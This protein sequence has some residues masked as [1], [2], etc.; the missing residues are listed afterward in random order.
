MD[1]LRIIIL[2][3]L[4]VGCSPFPVQYPCDTPKFTISDKSKDISYFDTSG[5][6]E[7]YCPAKV[8]ERF[9]LHLNENTK[10]TV[11]VRGEWI[12]LMPIKNGAQY[13]VTGKEIRDMEFEGYTQAI[14]V[15][16]LE[17]NTLTLSFTDS[18]SININVSLVKC[19]CVTYD[20]I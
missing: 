19:T 10:V 13:K 1:L 14:R 15:D 17:N 12:D 18:E 8:P 3:L 6:F 7:K 20:A 4:L 9:T 11:R 16:A 2:S 5:Y